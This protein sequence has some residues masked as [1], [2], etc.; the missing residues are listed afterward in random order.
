MSIQSLLSAAVFVSALSAQV[1]QSQLAQLESQDICNP[2]GHISSGESDNFRV[3]QTV[4]VGDVILNPR[5]AEFL[6]MSNAVVVPLEGNRVIVSRS[7]C[8]TR[9]AVALRECDHSTWLGRQLCDIPKGAV[10]QFLVLEPDVVSSNNRPTISWEAVAEATS[11][12]V[13]LQGSDIEWQ[14]EV[15]AND[16]QLAYPTNESSLSENSYEILV[17]ANIGGQ[18][19]LTASKVVNIHALSV[20]DISVQLVARMKGAQ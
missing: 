13:Y 12:S 4:C 3:R 16:T 15:S 5:R 1:V 6:C 10:E 11:Y 18:E 9:R 19:V 14:R 8:S 17:V 7:L 2:I 20:S